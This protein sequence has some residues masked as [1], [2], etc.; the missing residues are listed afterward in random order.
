MPEKMIYPNFPH[1]D[2]ELPYVRYLPKEEESE[3]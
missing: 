2:K 3:G 1:P